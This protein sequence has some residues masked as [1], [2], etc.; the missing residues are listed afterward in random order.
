MSL[1]DN[2]QADVIEAFNSA[3][4]YLDKTLNIDN[5]YFVQMILCKSDISQKPSLKKANSLDFKHFFDSDLSFTNGI[6]SSKITI[7]EAIS[8]CRCSSFLFLWRIYFA[9]YLLCK[10]AFK[11]K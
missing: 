1:S 10:S 4:R 7:N 5:P 3:L 2:N 6:V 11:C 9:A 8:G